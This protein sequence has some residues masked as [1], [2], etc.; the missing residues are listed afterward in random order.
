VACD[1]VLH[2]QVGGAIRYRRHL[3]ARPLGQH[4]AANVL[5]R[6]DAR[7]G[8]GRLGIG[9]E[10]GDQFGQRL[11]RHARMCHQQ[12]G[13]RGHVVEI[14][15]VPFGVVAELFLHD[16]GV[17]REPC[18]RCDPQ[19]VAVRGR[20]GHVGDTCGAAAAS[21]VFDH[22]LLAEACRKPFGEDAR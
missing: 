1:K 6:S 13:L 10:P 16:D 4:L 20:L 11:R 7:R 19:R 8:I 3:D 12:V 15:D 18:R 22:E 9:L 2:L 14:G 17:A 5:A 21:S